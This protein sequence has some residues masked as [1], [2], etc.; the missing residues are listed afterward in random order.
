MLTLF[1]RLEAWFVRRSAI[2]SH[3]RA[4]YYAALIVPLLLGLQSLLLGQDDG[5]DMRNYHLYNPY[6]LLNGRLAIDFSPAGF[7]S[8]FNPLLDLPYY[9]LTR[10]APAP[11][12]GFVFGWLHGLNFIPLSMM[13][14]QLL[15]GRQRVALLLA[16]AGCLGA[17]FLSEL[18]NSMGDNLTAL[19]L[20][21]AL[22]LLLR[23]GAAASVRIL[24]LAGLLMGAAA[25]LKLTNINYAVALCLA[26]LVWPQA[27]WRRIGQAWWFGVGVLAGLAAS[28]GY[29]WATMWRLYGNPLFPQFNDIFRSPLAAPLGVLD[30]GHLPHT[31]AE[32]LFWPFIFTRDIARIAEVPL[33]QLIWPLLMLLMLA[34]AVRLLWCR[35]RSSSVAAPQAATGMAALPVALT[36]AARVLLVFVLLAY[37][38]WLK[39]FSIYRYLVPLELLAPLLVWL[40]CHALMPAARAGR[41]A[42]WALAVCVLYTL[43]FVTWGHG[44]WTAQAFRAEAPQLAQPQ[45]SVV[46]MVRTPMAWLTRFF[47]PEVAFMAIGSGFPESPAYLQRLQEQAAART[48]QHYVMLPAAVNIR[49]SG[50]ERKLALARGL[51]LTA[52]AAGC[53]RLDGWLHKVRFQVE[54]RMLA[55]A[56]AAASGQAC[57]LL[58]QPQYRVDLAAEDA[59][60][61]AEVQ[62]HLAH[63]GLALQPDGCRNYPAYVGTEAHPYRLC[64]VQRLP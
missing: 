35:Y 33:R 6:A 58:L 39:L 18:G 43:P 50:A 42:G 10:Y 49:Q 32:A 51:G 30:T 4:P 29:W 28:T 34:Y 7:Q 9:L 55:A 63:Y 62:G 25:G 52:S 5:W 16:L 54:V 17:G 20:L 38:I 53:A 45:A 22:A 40:L 15:P 8:Y 11:L 59:A 31:L 26:L 27:F 46:Y 36:P 13:A 12:A 1:Q 23:H 44:G 37:L 41:W 48:G 3:P 61:Q 60:L 57:T 24:L 2:L 64:P 47:Q 14:R 56:D 19:P 21:W